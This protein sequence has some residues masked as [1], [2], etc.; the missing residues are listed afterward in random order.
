MRGGHSLLV[1]GAFLSEAIPGFA[2]AVEGHIAPSPSSTSLPKGCG[3]RPTSWPCKQ[4]PVKGTKT[5]TVSPHHKMAFIPTTCLWHS[6]T[7]QRL[8]LPSP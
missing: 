8:R 5:C 3:W 2:R 1:G 6:A 4:P 7:T